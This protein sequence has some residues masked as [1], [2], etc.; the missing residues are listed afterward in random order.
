MR[1]TKNKLLQV[2]ITGLLAFFSSCDR[3]DDNPIFPD[4][5]GKVG[6]KSGQ[7][8][9]VPAWLG[10]PNGIAAT[11][12][13]DQVVSGFNINYV[14]GYAQFGTTN[15]LDAGVVTVNGNEVAKN[16]SGNVIYYSSFNALSPSTL[17]GVNFNGSAH[18]WSVGGKNTIP[19]FD[20]VASS[21]HEF[22]LTS[23]ASGAS[24]SKSSDLN[25]TWSVTG[26]ASDSVMIYLTPATGSATPYVSAI[27]A[28]NG[29]A[30]ISASD[31]SK[32]SGA[33][34]LQVVKFRYAYTTKS[35]KLYFAIS[36]IVKTSAV[37]LN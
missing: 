37:T 35:G 20:I 1:R 30:K 17:T 28:N 15:F 8:I 21:P 2:A 36:E 19:Q 31:V 34:I 16:S 18:N 7:Q 5:N 22:T 24:V 10:A 9:P 4:D 6:N 14:M 32:F 23:P 25:I 33:A 27:L 13:F 29:A 3:I 26:G 11:I 12:S